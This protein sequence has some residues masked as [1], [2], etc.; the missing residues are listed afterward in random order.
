[1]GRTR[2]HTCILVLRSVEGFSDALRL[3]EAVYAL[4]GEDR[5]RRLSN[6]GVATARNLSV[7]GEDDRSVEVEERLVRLR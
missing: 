3:G 2:T 1:M 4:I 5:L 6:V 7:D